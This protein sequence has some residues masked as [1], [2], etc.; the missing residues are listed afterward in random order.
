MAMEIQLQK[1]RRIVQQAAEP[2]DK[3][4]LKIGGVFQR[5][6]LR[7]VSGGT[8]EWKKLLSRHRVG[9]V[10]SLSADG[11]CAWRPEQLALEQGSVFLVEQLE[12]ALMDDI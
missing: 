4:S 9:V 11:C 3:A 5:Q 6:M 10:L 1:P 8:A 7:V 2:T 12:H